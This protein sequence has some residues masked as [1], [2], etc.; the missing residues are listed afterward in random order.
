MTDLPDSFKQ[1]YNLTEQKW[2]EFEFLAYNIQMRQF[3]SEIR[4]W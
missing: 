1:K 3:E 4:G 2:N